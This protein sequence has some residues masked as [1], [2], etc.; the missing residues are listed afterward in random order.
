[1]NINEKIEQTFDEYIVRFDLSDENGKITLDHKRFIE[2]L[3]RIK[4]EVLSFIAP[5]IINNKL[6]DHDKIE[7]LI[8]ILYASKDLQCSD[9]TKGLDLARKVMEL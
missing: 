3:C 2:G 6:S 1:M 4:D 9:S 5:D 7:T 8:H